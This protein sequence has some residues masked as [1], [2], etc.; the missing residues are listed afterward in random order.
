M[1]LGFV[2]DMADLLSPDEEAALT[3]RLGAFE[4]RTR[5]RVVVATLP[6]LRGQ[7]MDAVVEDLGNRLGLHDGVILVVALKE[8]QVRL[9]VGRG[10]RKL[11]TDAEA[12]RIVSDVM[13]PDLHANR[14]DKGILKGADSIMAEL[15]ETKA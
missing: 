2:V 8:R 12:K 3:R 14:F 13:V 6:T 15:S 5:Q 7:A 11:L 4:V 1:G 9:A 10:A